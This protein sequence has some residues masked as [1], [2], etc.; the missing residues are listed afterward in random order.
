[1]RTRQ[2]LEMYDTP[3]PD[4]IQRIADR[5]MGGVEPEAAAIMEGAAGHKIAGWVK[6]GRD[7]LASAQEGA[8]LSRFAIFVIAMHTSE[9]RFLYLLRQRARFGDTD[10]AIELRRR[11]NPDEAGDIDDYYDGN[12]KF[13]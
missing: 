9:Q 8:T 6:Q 7:E 10:A 1:M 13:L 3:T 12:E 11:L 2:E 5:V 4:L